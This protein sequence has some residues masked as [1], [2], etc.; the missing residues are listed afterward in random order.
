[1]TV[2]FQFSLILKVRN[3]YCIEQILVEQA[4]KK[5]EQIFKL[6]WIFHW[7]FFKQTIIKT[8]LAK[9]KSNYVIKNAKLLKLLFNATM[10]YPRWHF[11]EYNHII[12]VSSAFCSFILLLITLQKINVKIHYFL[13]INFSMSCMLI[14]ATVSLRKIHVLCLLR[15]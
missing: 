12:P 15:F 1:M 2:I 9:K 13:K 5:L 4:L 8:H 14:Y 7:C 6:V 10:L 3:V 11:H